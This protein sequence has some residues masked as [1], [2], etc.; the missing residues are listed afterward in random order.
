MWITDEPRQSASFSGL[1]PLAPVPTGS[2][3]SGL[4][5]SSRTATLPERRRPPR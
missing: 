5:G 1:L 2:G 3:A 4:N